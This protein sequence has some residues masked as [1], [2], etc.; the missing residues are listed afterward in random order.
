[1]TNKIYHTVE[2]VP[3]SNKNKLVNDAKL[4][5]LTQKYMTIH[6]PGYVWR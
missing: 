6:F 4:L 2:T 1:M 3:K 5:P